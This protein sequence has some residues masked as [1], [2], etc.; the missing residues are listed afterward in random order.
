[1]RISHLSARTGVSIPSIKFYLREGLLDAGERTSRTQAEYGERH[2]DRLRVIKALSEVP[3]LS[4]NRIRDIL[5]L[6]DNPGEDLLGALGSASKQ[7]PPYA[8]D[9]VSLQDSANEV[10]TRLSGSADREIDALGQ[11]GHALQTAQAANLPV[12]DERLEVYREHLGAIA[13][14]EIAT[15]PTEPSDALTYAV[16]GTVLYEPLLLA[17]RRIALQEEATAA[18]SGPGNAK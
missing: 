2:V 8:D 7:L 4:I 17:L 18:L 12:S 14:Y 15:M 5:A 6:I 16:I 10:L 3:G 11:L 1:M 9:N 13:A